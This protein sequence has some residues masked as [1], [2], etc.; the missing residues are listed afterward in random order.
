MAKFRDLSAERLIN[1]TSGPLHAAVPEGTRPE[2]RSG[3]IPYEDP[4]DA[5]ICLTCPLKECILDSGLE[6]CTRY[7]RVKGK[8]RKNEGL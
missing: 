3:P 7:E 6:Y 8:E 4:D 1:R 5:K 2:K